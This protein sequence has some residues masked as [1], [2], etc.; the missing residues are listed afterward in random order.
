MDTGFIVV[1]RFETNTEDH[2]SARALIDSYIGDF[3]A[4]QPG[5]IEIWLTEGADGAGL[6]HFARWQREEDF[7]AFAE[8]ARSHPD[9]DKIRAFSPSPAFYRPVA[10]YGKE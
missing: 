8:K 6:L 4:L 3:L 7:R 9:L 10:R 2:D 5:F 1:V